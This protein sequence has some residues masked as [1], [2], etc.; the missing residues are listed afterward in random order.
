[1]TLEQRD[2][3][4]LKDSIDQNHKAIM[5]LL[6][7]RKDYWDERID[8]ICNAMTEMKDHCRRQQDTCAIVFKEFNKR[9]DENCTD[10]T[11]IKTIGGVIVFIW[12]AV[13]AMASHI[14][15]KL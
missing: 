2:Y 1:M 9:I 11:K 14:L 13:V 8:K 7:L 15:K 4:A 5:D 10:I 12:G 3:T 6:A